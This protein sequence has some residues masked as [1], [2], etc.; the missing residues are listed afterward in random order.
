VGLDIDETSRDIAF[1][2]YSILTP[3]QIM[4]IPNTRLDQR[5]SNNPLVNETPKIR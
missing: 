2:A 3:D 1:C 4:E 5:F